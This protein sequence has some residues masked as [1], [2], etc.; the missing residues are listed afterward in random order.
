MREVSFSE[1]TSFQEGLAP[2]YNKYIMGIREPASR[3][4]ILG[5]ILHG[6]CLEKKSLTEEL[7]KQYFTSDTIRVCKKILEN[8]IWE[9]VEHPEHLLVVPEKYQARIDDFHSNVPLIR[10]LKT[11]E[12]LW[13]QDR[14]DQSTQLTF[15]AMVYF[16]LFGTI[17]ELEI[18]SAS[19][20]SG[21]VV[22]LKTQRDE[23]QIEALRY[24]VDNMI[25]FL[26][27]HNLWEKRIKQK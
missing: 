14:A 4:M 3:P 24:E 20:K 18:I 2:Y 7:E 11:G 16:D 12:Q 25:D 1:F 27:R 21:K 9:E 5:N 6:A 8:P 22:V 10:D 17:P 19:T 13:T 23:F 26:K 15:Y